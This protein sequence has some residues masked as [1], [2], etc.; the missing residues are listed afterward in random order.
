MS[1]YSPNPV[2]KYFKCIVDTVHVTKWAMYTIT[3]FYDSY[4]FSFHSTL[5]SV[6][7]F[8]ELFFILREISHGWRTLLPSNLCPPL[9]LVPPVGFQSGAATVSHRRPRLN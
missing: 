9:R 8:V 1:T 3:L 4:A 6:L 7:I 5:N 2:L